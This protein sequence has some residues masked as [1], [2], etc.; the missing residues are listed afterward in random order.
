MECARRRSWRRRAEGLTSREEYSTFSL[1][2]AAVSAVF[3]P[4]AP[5]ERLLLL[6][7]GAKGKRVKSIDF[8][9]QDMIRISFL[10]KNMEELPYCKYPPTW[11]QL[12]QDDTSL[13]RLDGV[14]RFVT[15][16]APAEFYHAL[17]K[18]NLA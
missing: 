11:F 16:E 17:G 10:A 7:L 15:R 14:H 13:L 4:A 6:L 1:G 18:P 8:C 9:V 2:T 3:A 12:M 5:E